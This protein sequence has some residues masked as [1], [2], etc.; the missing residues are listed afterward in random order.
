MNAII[1]VDDESIVLT[2]LKT[3]LKKEFGDRF[4][5]ET[6]LNAV[7]AMEI[8]D[9]LN[10]EGVEIILIIS[11]WLMPGIKGDEFLMEVYRK[12][13]TIK[14]ILLTGMINEKFLDDLYTKTNLIKIIYK[15]WTKENLINLIKDK[16]I[17][18]D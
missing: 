16:V 2:A 7:D 11:D 17:N 8:I 13:P 12:H 14:A 10:K 3:T 6:A 15:P 5:Y 9:D 18:S 4:I 1:C